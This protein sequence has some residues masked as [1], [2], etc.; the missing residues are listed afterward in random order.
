M[1]T[2]SRSDWLASR[3]AWDDGGFGYRWQAIRSIAADRGFIYPPMGSPHDDR[4]AEQP[5]HR[6]VI[7]RAL[8]DNPRQLEGIVRRS[9]SWKEVVD[10]IYGLEARLRLDADDEERIARWER[11]EEKSNVR[12]T[13]QG[14]G[15]IL[16]RWVDSV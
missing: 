5:S 14:V 8:E 1:R 11:D 13:I 4:D 2:Y 6:A 3:K 10:G 9:R 15:Q 12:D 16:R 7:W